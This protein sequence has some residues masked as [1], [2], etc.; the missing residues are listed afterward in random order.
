[1]YHTSEC[2]ASWGALNRDEELE[3]QLRRNLCSKYK[4][5]ALMQFAATA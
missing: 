1:M 4:E 2:S 5:H 3:L